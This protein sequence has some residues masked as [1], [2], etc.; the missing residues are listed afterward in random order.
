[1]VHITLDFNLVH[2]Q[3]ISCAMLVVRPPHAQHT[4]SNIHFQS[5]S[6]FHLP[7]TNA[8]EFVT[9]DTAILALLSLS[10]PAALTAVLVRTLLRRLLGLQLSSTSASGHQFSDVRT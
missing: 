10:R 8:C 5:Y 2:L 9:V 1:M 7:P 6:H 4:L 3:P